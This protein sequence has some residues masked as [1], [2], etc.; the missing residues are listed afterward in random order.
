M[1]AV[2][3][4]L[5]DTKN[6]WQ[7]PIDKSKVPPELRPEYRPFTV[8]DANFEQEFY[9]RYIGSPYVNENDRMTG[10][11]REEMAKADKSGIVK[12]VTDNTVF[13]TFDDWGND[14]SINHILY[15]LR[16]HRVPGTFFIITWNMPNNPNLLRAI[17]A[18]GHA[19][20]SH[21]NQHKA[22]NRRDEKGKQ[23]SVLSE[24]EYAADIRESFQ[25][26]SDTIGDM[27]VNGRPPLT[28]L[29]RP[30]TLAVSRSGARAIFDAGLTFIVNGF[31][32][33]EDYAQQSL[34]AMVGALQNGIYRRNE[35]VRK[36]SI[37]VMHMSAPAKYTA[38]ALDLLLTANERRPDGD[39]A[40]FRVGRIEDY[41]TE[42]YSQTMRRVTDLSLR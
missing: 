10:F 4:V 24:E 42:D 15:V 19:I 26:L 2:G 39:P 31:E 27:T 7:Y 20:G 33:T 9:R 17:A 22:M 12:N 3:D 23:V 34:S 8:D 40:K 29:M 36:G 11:S 25:R 6:L 41:L 1:E 16:K 37:L 38:R 13:L 30:P 5:A 35:T 21:T 14:D 32:S 18:D 28:R